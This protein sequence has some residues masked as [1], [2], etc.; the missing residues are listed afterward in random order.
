[1]CMCVCVLC[2]EV[3]CRKRLGASPPGNTHQ[4]RGW[5]RWWRG[6]RHVAPHWEHPGNSHCSKPH[7]PHCRPPSYSR[8]HRTP[9]T[10]WSQDSA[11]NRPE[12]KEEDQRQRR[13]FK[14]RLSEHV[15]FSKGTLIT[16]SVDPS[17]SQSDLLPA[18]NYWIQW[19]RGDREAEREGGRKGER[20]S[21]YSAAAAAPSPLQQSKRLSRPCWW[22]TSASRL[23]A[24]FGHP[25][26]L[27]PHSRMALHSS[28]GMQ[29]CSH[30]KTPTYKQQQRWHSEVHLLFLS[31]C[32][33]ELSRPWR[34]REEGV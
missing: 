9:R 3:W 24:V 6:G 22:E 29:S 31:L 18:P 11:G 32:K 33:R 21:Q 30:T 14:Q 15:V 25:L 13:D 16:S 12:E 10:W 34:T 28:T 19:G 20:Q 23:P 5:E 8:S 4:W 2:R 7:H 26:R 17:N 1:M 27:K